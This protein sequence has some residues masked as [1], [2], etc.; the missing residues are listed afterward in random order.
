MIRRALAGAALLLACLAAPAGAQLPLPPLGQGGPDP[1]PYGT[2]DA[3]G[4]RNVLPPG[5]NG[6]DNVTDFAAFESNGTRPRHFDDQLKLYTDLIYAAPNLQHD[7]LGDYFKDATFGVRPEDVETSTSPRAGVT[8]VRDKQYGVP[9]VYGATRADVMFGAGYAGAQD[10]LF[11]M[12]VLRHTGRAELSSFIGGAASNREMDRLQWQLAPYTEADLQRQIDLAEPVYGARG[13][14]VHDDLVAYVE[15]INQ[16]ISEAQVD[17]SKK[18]AEY[19]LLGI[20]LEPWKA[21][22][23]IATA[24]LIGGIFGKGGGSELQSALTFQAFVDRFGRRRG[25]RAWLDFR[26]KNDPEAP[27]T[28]RRKFPY[29]T[30]SPFARTGLAMPDRSSVAAAPPAPPPEEEG[31]G[32]ASSRTGALG[33]DP[34]TIFKRRNM[35]NAL[36]VPG[37]NSATGHP[38][39]VMGPQVGYYVPQILMEQDLHGPGID[40]RGA[41]FPGV[42]LYVQLGHG[43]DYAWSATTAYSDNVDTFAEKLCEDDFHYEWR[44]Q[45]VAMER[46]D[47]TNSWTPNA[48]DTTPPGSETLTVYRTVHGIVTHRARV[49]GQKVAYVSARSTYFHEADSALGFAALNDPGAVR[50]AASFKRA[51]ADINFA[52]NWFYTDSEDIAYFQSGAYPQRAPGTSPDFPIWGT[53]EHDWRDMNTDI[54]TAALI[55]DR[56][57]PQA[58]NQQHIVSWNNKQAP[59]WAAADDNYRFGSVF[60]SQLLTDPLDRDLRR[61]RK[62]TLE[63]LTQIMAQAGTQDLRGVKMLPVLLRAVGKPRDARL[64]AAVHTLRAWRRA[65]AHRRDLDR[66]GHY[67]HDDAVTIM[68]AWWPRLQAAQFRPVL[69]KR[70]YGALRRM[71]PPGEAKETDSHESPA[72]ASDLYGQSSKDLRTV[73]SRRS[74]RPRGAFSRKYCGRGSRKACR[75]ALRRSL[76]QALD[77]TRDQLYGKDAD[78]ASAGRVEAACSDETRSTSASGIS[79]D[80]FP[81]QN[82]PTFQQIVQLERRVPR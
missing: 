1:A 7:Q 81:F 50:D 49:R 40:A 35:S 57:H 68:D 60:R 54:R 22:D 77:V 11:L 48:L 26:Q 74:R 65:G 15:G 34:R 53:G 78:C 38:I 31:S 75:R 70:V 37:R 36:L 61:G 14:V 72:F 10:R 29:E 43:R 13:K 58:V 24:S 4:F 42:N 76:A 32:S 67:D 63:R 69:G 3:G 47:R 6:L 28:V 45:C 17:P 33:F 19:S 5:S 82:R 8:I 12:D 59:R 18:P 2:D 39:A 44:G 23:V 55:P 62:I 21:T 66:D 52:F 56:R 30:G 51:A 16:Y 20:P 46:L 64:A 25:K 80:P 79:I 27:V 41:A 9:H 71:V 73:F